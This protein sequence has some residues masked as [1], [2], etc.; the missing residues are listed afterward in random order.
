MCG[1]FII[2]YIKGNLD[3]LNVN[4]AFKEMSVIKAT[5][6]GYKIACSHFVALQTM[7]THITE[8]LKCYF[9]C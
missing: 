3:F 6:I 5:M 2:V 1:R 4:S 8:F 9:K 7:A